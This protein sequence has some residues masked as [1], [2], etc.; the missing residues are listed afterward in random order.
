MTVGNK[1]IRS[2]QSAANIDKAWTTLLNFNINVHLGFSRMTET[3]LL[4]SQE[5]I[6]IMLIY[7][8]QA[9]GESV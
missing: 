8:S 2:Y 6:K 5:K 3:K 7:Y 4:S 9:G 1:Q